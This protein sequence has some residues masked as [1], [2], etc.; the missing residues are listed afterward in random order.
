M[1]STLLTVSHV[2][3]FLV[4][5]GPEIWGEAATRIDVDAARE[6][7]SWAHPFGTDNAGRDVLARM[8]PFIKKA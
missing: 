3:V 5:A 6:G 8:L 7:A 2:L 1:I 4:V